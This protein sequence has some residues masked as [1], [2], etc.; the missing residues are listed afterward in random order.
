MCACM[1]VCVYVGLWVLF[2][3]S[4]YIFRSTLMLG[5][6]AAARIKEKYLT[7]F[8]FSGDQI[9]DHYQSECNFFEF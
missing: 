6:C 4:F 7:I 8:I 2:F 9:S 5:L 3:L 1:C